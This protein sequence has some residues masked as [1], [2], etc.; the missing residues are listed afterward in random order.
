MAGRQP[1]FSRIAVGFPGVVKDGI[2][3]TA[4]NLHPSWRE[5]DLAALLRQRL[6]RPA[7]VLNDAAVQGLGA[8]KGH[9]VELVITLG[10]GFGSALFLDGRY[11]TS[12]ELGHHPFRRGQTYEETFG[13]KSLERLGPKRW[14]KRLRRALSTLDHVFNFDRL[15]I[16]GGNAKKINGPLPDR[17]ALVPNIA[18]LLGGVALWRDE[19]QPSRRRGL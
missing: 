13:R 15:Y 10:T 4:P 6:R 2:V 1:P 18:G 5:T 14:N 3:K 16:G 19:K 9:G 11:V 8:I 7:R 12:L 17:V